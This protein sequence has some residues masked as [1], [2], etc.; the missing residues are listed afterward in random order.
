MDKYIACDIEATTLDTVRGEGSIHCIAFHNDD[1]SVCYEWGDKAIDF[2]AG[3]LADGYILVFHSAQYDVPSLRHFTGFSLPPSQFRCT[4]V[5]AHAVNPQLHSYSLDS[6]TG[7]KM[8]YG[9]EMVKAGK[10]VRTSK[11]KTWEKEEMSRLFAIP[12][13]SILMAYNLQ[14]ARAA[15]GEWKALQ[16]HLERD[17]RLRTAYETI[18]NPF[19]D[20]VISMHGGMH[21]DAASMYNLMLDLHTEYV[22]LM[23]E[24]LEKHRS[25]PKLRWEKADKMWVPTGELVPPNL[26]S[27]ADVAS[28]LY[29]AGWTP[30]DFSNDTGRPCTD[31]YTLQ[32]LVA[33]DSTPRPV[34]EVVKDMLAIRSIAGIKSQCQSVLDIMTE[35]RS[36]TLHANW[37]QTGTKTGRLSSSSPNMQNFSTR[38]P[39]WG[40]RMRACFTPPPGYS[41]LVG[42][43]SQV[44]LAVL[45]YY[46]E[47]Y[48]DDSAMAQAVRDHEDIHDAN[49]RNWTGVERGDEGFKAKRAICKNGAFAS[50]YGAREKRL[51]LTLCITLAEA[52][53][54]LHTLESSVPIEAL[55]QFVYDVA[56]SHRDIEP[57]RYQFKRCTAGFFYDCMSVRHFYPDLES[58]DR[59]LRS[60]AERQVFNCLMQGGVGSMFMTLCLRL[61]PYLNRVGGWISATVHDEIIFVVPDEYAL[62]ALEEGNKCFNSI[63]LGD[64]STGRY[65]PIRSS[66][67]I[68]SNWSE[69]S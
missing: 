7:N 24:F 30:S 51:A 45:A 34:V 66:F 25:I 11:K 41:M 47:L 6:L 19:V 15:W 65:V 14:D 53:E 20:V 36:T 58:R 55:K 50:S 16:P 18:Q 3:L 21:V 46:L 5:L 61:L 35:Q 23:E 10:F 31:K 32:S 40:K 48:M 68:V 37:H 39:K 44:E 28:L 43:L 56:S 54:I 52:R 33:K 9:E 22:H 60:K 1:I 69:K 13:N 2:L 17:S 26:S 49:T 57:V 8:H 63:T 59:Y 67:D 12:C 4:Q 64:E 27:P 38:H 42:D 29:L 62:E